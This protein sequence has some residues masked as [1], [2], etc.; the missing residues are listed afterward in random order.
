MMSAAAGRTPIEAVLFDLDGVI[1]DSEPWWHAVRVEWAAARGLTWTED[2]NRACMGR[3]S[4]DW[5]RIMQERLRLD[6]TIPQIERVIMD[7]LVEKYA[8]EPAPRVPGAV[9][10]VARIAASFP[11]AIASSAHPAVIR[12]ALRSVG[13]A[14]CFRVIVSADD[15]PAG[16][17]APDVYL[18]AARRLG[19]PPERCLVVE[20]SLNGVLAGRAAGMTVVLVPNPSFLP[21]EGTAEAADF[22]IARLADLDPRRSPA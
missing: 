19:V 14:E 2:D 15:V 21:G 13:L 3:N 12:A 22:V 5:A 17:P 10:A 1:V 6:L 7:A 11:S 16:K 4:R 18:E 20:D 9:E 8:H